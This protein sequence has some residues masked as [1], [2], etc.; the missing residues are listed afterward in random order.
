[1]T[2]TRYHAL[3]LVTSVVTLAAGV[4]VG[5]GPL[6][7]HQDR[8]TTEQTHQLRDRQAHL[9]DRIDALTSRGRADRKLAATLAAPLLDGALDDR[10]VLVVAA[11][12]ADRATVRRTAKTL[13]RA[14]ATV[15][16]TLTV[17]KEYVDPSN[18]QSPLE[19]LALRLVPPNVSFREGATP[20]D[21]VGTVLARSTVTDDKTASD[22]IDQKAAEVIAGLDELGAI[23]LK[24]DPGLLAQL[25]VV[26]AGPAPAAQTE[27]TIGAQDAL[28]GLV[29]ALESGSS[30]TVVIGTPDNLGKGSLLAGLRESDV[31]RRPTTVDAAGSVSGDL[32][33][34]LG[35][36]EQVGG[37]RG[38]YGT[39]AGADALVPDLRGRS[40]S[41]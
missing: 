14:G 32:G 11:P 3:A 37:A 15:T 39:G 28:L 34:V 7:E 21:R 22:K 27:S 31:S 24:G 36:V 19:D 41:G 38:D 4:A 6:S 29:T 35:L 17:T 1:V 26:V 40:S 16:G 20:I 12:G 18:A 8:R 9:L 13:T 23:S 5:V 10:T 2:G 33:L 30:G 25:A